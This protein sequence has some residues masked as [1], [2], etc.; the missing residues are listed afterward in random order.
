MKT[1]ER[2]M[3]FISIAHEIASK[4]VFSKK[5]QKIVMPTYVKHF[6]HRHIL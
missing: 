4:G 6:A 5:F 1:E 2:G 3:K